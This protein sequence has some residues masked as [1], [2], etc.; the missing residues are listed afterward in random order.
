MLTC[1]R[2]GHTPLA[3][4]LSAWNKIVRQRIGWLVKIGAEKQKREKRNK[5]ENASKHNTSI[6][7]K[8]QFL[9]YQQFTFIVWHASS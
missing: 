7:A 5:I 1:V 8:H 3:G 4:S 9:Y 6:L 2:V